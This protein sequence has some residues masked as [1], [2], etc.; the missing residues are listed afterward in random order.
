MY[1]KNKVMFIIFREDIKVIDIFFQLPNYSHF[2][3]STLSTPFCSVKLIFNEY[4][5]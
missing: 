1:D 2:C 4:K 5:F 3:Y